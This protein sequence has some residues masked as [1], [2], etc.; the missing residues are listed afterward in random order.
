MPTIKATPAEIAELE[1]QAIASGGS[2]TRTKLVADEEPATFPVDISEKDFQ[3]KVSKAARDR[4]WLVYHTLNSRGS[5]AGFP[6]LVL[7]RPGRVIF[8]ELKATKGTVSDEQEVW[9]SVLALAQS[10]TLEVY[11]FRPIDWPEILKILE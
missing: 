8:A 4:K 5:A 9:I 3:A 11:L 7:A 1:R 6:D 10:R 2:V